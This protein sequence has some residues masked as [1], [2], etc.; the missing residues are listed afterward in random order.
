MHRPFITI[1][2]LLFAAACGSQPAPDGRGRPV[3]ESFTATPATIAPGEEST[4]SWQV[5][6][7]TSL[8]LSPGVGAVEGSS[9]TVQPTQTTE[10]T[11]TAANAAGETTA[12]TTVT[13]TGSGDGDGVGNAAPLRNTIAYATEGG[14][15]IRLINPDGGNDRRL[16]AHALADPEGVYEVYSLAWSPDARQLAFASSHERGCSLNIADIYAVDADGSDYRRLT[17]GPACAALEPYPKGTVR[18]PVRNDGF[19]S[20]SGFL[21]FQGAPG[22]QPVTLPPL[23]SSVV[24]FE[25]VADLGPG[26][27]QVAALIAPNDAF[28]LPDAR[29]LLASTAVD[30]QAGGTVTTAEAGVAVPGAP[31]ESRSPSWKWDGSSLAFARNFNALLEISPKPGPLEFGSSLLAEGAQMPFLVLYAARGPTAATADQLLHT[32]WGPGAAMA[33]YLT[34]EGAAA[35]G[36]PLLSFSTYESVFGLAWLPDGSG[37]AYTVSAGA[38]TGQVAVSSG[39][40]RFVFERAERFNTTTGRL[41]DI[42]LWLVNRDGSGVTR[43]AQGAYAPAWSR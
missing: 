22:V 10:Y 13:V 33:I 43:L 23:G 11:L 2:F 9:R 35:V 5:T 7:A 25:N 30:V 40:E 29:E 8:N 32:G 15:E 34:A 37:F 42:D 27:L 20:F 14:D 31:L 4:L 26:T 16:W 36:E 28:N 6:G 1:L 12:K 17:Q 21:Y 38:Y 41:E 19:S 3:I 24:T 39:G 18:V